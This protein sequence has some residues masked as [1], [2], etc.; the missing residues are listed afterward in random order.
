MLF[1]YYDRLIIEKCAIKSEIT[2][3]KSA[4]GFFE[5]ENERRKQEIQDLSRQLCYLLNYH[6]N[7]LVPDSDDDFTNLTAGGI[8]TKKLVT[9][10]DIEELQENN[11]KLLA[12][13]R[14]LS[15]KKEEAESMDLNEI[16]KLKEDYTKI[17]AQ[18]QELLENYATQSDILKLTISQRDSM[19]H[20]GRGDISMESA[21][22][23]MDASYH[24]EQNITS[25]SGEVVEELRL[26]L[27][28]TEQRLSDVTKEFDTYR[29]ERKENER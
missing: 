27:T 15:S 18:H 5:R 8:I 2:E 19:K 9:F 28:E 21:P 1:Y 16:V 29:I 4:T 14:E 20:L 23:A 10:K 17:S 24:E 22:S 13:V 7:K 25:T 26:K 12:L 3:A 6:R 11:R